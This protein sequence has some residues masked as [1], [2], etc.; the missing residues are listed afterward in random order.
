MKGGTMP[1][2][3]RPEGELLVIF[4]RDGERDE[5][6]VAP[7][8]E[9]ACQTAVLMI[10]GRGVLYAGDQLTVSEYDAVAEEIT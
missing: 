5:A 4:S 1:A 7:S 6:L 10:V 8:G 9:R 2:R 3:T